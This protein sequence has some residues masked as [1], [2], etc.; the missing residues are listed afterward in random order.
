MTRRWDGTM[1]RVDE[2]SDRGN[3]IPSLFGK[4]RRNSSKTK[5]SSSS[6]PI[7]RRRD[8]IFPSNSKPFSSFSVFPPV[9]LGPISLALASL[10]PSRLELRNHL[11][12]GFLP[13]HTERRS[14][15][16]VIDGL[17]ERDGGGSDRCP[18]RSGL[19][20]SPAPG[21]RILQQI[22]RTQILLQMEQPLKVQSLLV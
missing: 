14:I 22:H 10:S 12:P 3:R 5:L 15:E 19:V 21:H 4:Q 2:T 6:T 16:R 17:G 13:R 18:S 20:F 11:Y 9:F 7:R 8:H 1:R